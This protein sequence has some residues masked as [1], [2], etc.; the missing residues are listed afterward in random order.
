MVGIPPG[1]SILQLCLQ[2]PAHEVIP[3]TQTCFGA[4]K[5]CWVFNKFSKFIF[6]LHSLAWKSVI[7]GFLNI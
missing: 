7:L 5:S 6:C 3:A 2:H 1:L 4:R